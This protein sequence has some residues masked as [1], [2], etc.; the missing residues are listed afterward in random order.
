MYENSSS[1][2]IVQQCL[3]PPPPPF[4]VG[5]NPIA[6]TAK[7]YNYM[8]VAHNMGKNDSTETRKRHSARKMDE[9]ESNTMRQPTSSR[10]PR[11]LPE[12]VINRA[13]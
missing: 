4:P 12:A 11:K 10:L 6:V 3:I 1:P 9:I 13:I 5:E 2:Y 7:V 8:F